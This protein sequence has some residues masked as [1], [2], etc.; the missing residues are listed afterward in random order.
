MATWES[1]PAP[2]GPGPAFGKD[3][4]GRAGPAQKTK[5]SGHS[6]HPHA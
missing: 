5:T 2:A 4:E 1:G 3:G 6:A